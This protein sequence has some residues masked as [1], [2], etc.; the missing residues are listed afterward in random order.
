MKMNKYVQI[1]IFIILINSILYATGNYRSHYK[2]DCIRGSNV[3]QVSGTSLLS[4]KFDK[5]N[6]QKLSI[7]NNVSNSKNEEKIEYIKL[8]DISSKYENG[9]FQNIN[10]QYAN[11][12]SVI[13]YLQ[14][15]DNN[16]RTEN[17]YNVSTDFGGSIHFPISTQYNYT[18]S[19]KNLISGK[20]III[21]NASSRKMTYYNPNKRFGT[22]WP[23]DVYHKSI[24]IYDEDSRE[25]LYKFDKII[26]RLRDKKEKIVY[27]NILYKLDDFGNA[28]E[29][30]GEFA[31]LS[32]KF[33]QMDID[34]EFYNSNFSD[35]ANLPKWMY[36]SI[37]VANVI[38]LVNTMNINNEFVDL[39]VAQQNANNT[40]F[41]VHLSKHILDGKWERLPDYLNNGVGL[42]SA[43]IIGNLIPESFAVT[44]N[45]E[46]NKL[47][48]YYNP[49][50]IGFFE[51]EIFK[52]TN[53]FDNSADVI[54]TPENINV[55]L[56]NI[57]YYFTHKNKKT[58]S[59]TNDVFTIAIGNNNSIP[60]AVYQSNLKLNFNYHLNEK[61]TIGI[62]YTKYLIESC[63]QI[64]LYYNRQTNIKILGQN[65][66]TRLGC[67]F[68]LPS[69]D[70]VP[71]EKTYFTSYEDNAVLKNKSYS[72]LYF[73]PR[74]CYKFLFLY[75]APSIQTNMV[76]AK[77][78]DKTGVAFLITPALDVG[79][80]FGF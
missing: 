75:V 49:E 6:N 74:I 38:E 32:T 53:M 67:T 37:A 77:I 1:L 8:P 5:K 46:D 44:P 18:V 2:I 36:H 76:L 27:N 68:V 45:S 14:P 29:L 40:N 71:I 58:N 57:E 12:Y 55:S 23:I 63:N 52:K 16:N 39:T 31:D 54:V 72:T 21:V 56:D 50:N 15:T 80:N 17:N 7:L 30:Y 62:E 10:P 42:Q 65:I 66:S 28:I 9:I 34:T 64:S 4:Y 24:F 48:D 19:P 59:S 60:K 20:T 43:G 79:L 78:D 47:S 35:I 33:R 22:N 69:D 41:T 73:E 25:L 26:S 3:N 51:K 13:K 61:N 11:F 70:W